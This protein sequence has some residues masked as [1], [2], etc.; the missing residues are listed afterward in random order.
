DNSRAR[1]AVPA[2]PRR[3]KTGATYDGRFVWA[4]FA[5]VNQPAYTSKWLRNATK[6]PSTGTT[7]ARP[8]RS[9]DHA[10]DL[11]GQRQGAVRRLGRA[12]PDAGARLHDRHDDRGASGREGPPGRGA[13]ARAAGGLLPGGRNAR[14][15][16]GPEQPSASGRARA[17]LRRRGLRRLLRP[18]RP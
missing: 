18:A 8:P 9:P 13:S 14:G 16:P 2:A 7:T 3:A 10:R 12:G 6:E 4:T 15:F 11:V 5:T 17:A 1:T